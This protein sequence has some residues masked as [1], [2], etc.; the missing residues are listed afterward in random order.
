MLKNRLLISSRVLRWIIES[1]S[2]AMVV[3]NPSEQV[4]QKTSAMM[5]KHWQNGMQVPTQ[6]AM[7]MPHRHVVCLL[8]Q[9][10]F[11]LS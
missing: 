4:S 8:Q 9:T 11:G 7:E 1:A 3:R 5:Q 10:V 6:D 2:L